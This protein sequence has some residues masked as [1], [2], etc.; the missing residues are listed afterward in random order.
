VRLTLGIAAFA[1]LPLAPTAAGAQDAAELL[2]RANA[3]FAASH[4]A[5]SAYEHLRLASLTA[6]RTGRLVAGGRTVRFI[7]GTLSAGDSAR[8]AEGLTRAEEQLRMRFG[9]SASR[10][11]GGPEW[12]VSSLRYDRRFARYTSISGGESAAAMR[13]RMV[14]PVD[15]A[16]VEQFALGVAGEGL[17]RL[18]PRLT[19]FTG[20]AVTFADDP[21]RWV[22]AGR[23]L[24]L[25]WAVVGR[26]CA[27]GSVAACRAVFTL[28]PEDGGLAL[29]FEPADHRAVVTA[30]RQPK[31]G[32]SLF[33]ASRRRC[34][35][36]ADS[37]CTRIVG[38]LGIPDPFSQSLRA[39][40]AMQAIDLGGTDAI[41]R[42]EAVTDGTPLAQLAMVAGVSED[43]LVASWQRRVT[44]ALDAAQPRTAPL[45]LSIAGWS[46]LVL[47]GASR[48]K[49]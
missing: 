19:P 41:A 13:V 3:A 25:S 9:P 1:I 26:H 31:D 2:Q 18:A 16:T 48:R 5:D 45:A 7:P 32:D 35:A 14:G 44:A 28:P 43:S 23:E 11:I 8:I 36:G 12:T 40:L 24:A 33:F 34:L 10:L 49:P 29:Y 6:G 46:L 38:M 20:G 17:M 22:N 37:A 47:V 42:L 15:P 30:G 27:T 39:T 4:A 21:D